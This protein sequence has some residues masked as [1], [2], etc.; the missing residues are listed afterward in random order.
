LRNLVDGSIVLTDIND[1]DN[2][3]LI[4]TDFLLSNKGNDF[5][6]LQ[7]DGHPYEFTNY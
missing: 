7:I 6:D 4:S 3:A 5:N 1:A 2:Y